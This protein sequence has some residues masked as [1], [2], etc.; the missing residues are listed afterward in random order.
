MGEGHKCTAPDVTTTDGAPIVDPT[1]AAGS[2]G[3]STTG[4][5]TLYYTSKSTTAA[6]LS[7]MTT[8]LHNAFYGKAASNPNFTG[9]APVGDAFQRAVDGG[10]AKGS[11]FY[12]VDGTY[13]E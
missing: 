11:G 7:D 8:D 6:N 2:N 5:N 12:Q 13:D 3:S 1:C 4:Q 9:V 10:F